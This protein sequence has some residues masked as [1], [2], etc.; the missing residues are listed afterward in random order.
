MNVTIV[1]NAECIQDMSIG[2]E[3]ETST[4]QLFWFDCNSEWQLTFV[5]EGLDICVQVD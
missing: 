1:E 5:Q 2:G 4:G 3:K